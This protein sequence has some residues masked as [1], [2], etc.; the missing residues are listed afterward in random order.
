MVLKLLQ[1]M[2]AQY[3]QGYLFK[4]PMPLEGDQGY[5][6]ADSHGAA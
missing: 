2:G 4:H 5:A 3:G 6:I 1:K